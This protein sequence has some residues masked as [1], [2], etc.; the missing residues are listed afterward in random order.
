MLNRLLGAVLI[1]AQCL[2]G[3][4]ALAQQQVQPRAGE[5]TVA[6]QVA[7]DKSSPLLLQADDMIYD[8][9]N[10]RV[11][12]RG[13]VEIYYNDYVL[14]AD[15]VA[16]DRSAN[17]LTAI[18]NVRIKE[19]DGAVINA[20]RLTLRDDFRDGF[21]RSLR[22]VTQDDAR[23][24]ASNAY[25]KD[26]Q[27]TVY[28]NGVFTPCKPCE[29]HPERPPIWRVKSTKIIH[30]KAEQNIYYENAQFE[31][32]GIPVAWVPYFY[33][34]DPQVKQRSGFLMPYYSSSSQLGYTVAVPYYYAASPNYDLTLTPEFTTN[35]GYL[36]QTEW[37]QRLWDGAYKINLAG[38]Y[39]DNAGDFVNNRKFRGSVQTQGDFAIGSL[40]HFGWNATLESDDTF[41]RFYRLD[42]I[43]ATER[44]SQVY[45]TGI[46]D[47]NYF[48]MSLYRFGN[49]TGDTFNVDTGT[50]QKAI[51]ATAYPVID[52][53]YVHNKPV[54]GGEFSFDVNALALT[55]DDPSTLSSTF[56]R[57]TDHVVTQAQWRRTL[58]DDFGQRFTPFGQARG[59]VYHVSSF[60]DI[61]GDSG[62]DDTFTRQ[63]VLGGLDY[64]YPFVA[65]TDNASHVIEPVAQIIARSNVANNDKVP[66]EDSQS[67]VFDDT[68]LFDINKFSGY[69]RIETGTRANY[70]LQYTM[71]TYNGV[72]VRV[73]GGESVQVAGKNSFDPT[74]GLA[75]DRSD[76]VLGGYVDWR[77]MF[78]LV[79]QVRLNESDFSFSA[80]NYSVQ[81]KL[82]FFQGA[83]SYISVQPQP[84]LGFID[85]RQEVAGFAAFK[86]NDDW[87]VFG[88]L[89]YDVELGQFLR[90]SIG[91]QYSDE[92]FTLSVTYAQTFIEFQDIK[93]DTTVMVRLGL[94]YLG[95][96]T[97]SDSIGDLSPEAA[98]FK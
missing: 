67:L 4:S 79:S 37:R 70:G 26:G 32:F 18:G 91:V 44:I 95:Q 90:N 61:N 92:C 76:Y 96:Q 46:G 58:T 81:T 15:E 28:E 69:D 82:G 48:N 80:Q 42:S 50:Y 12:A 41:R 85:A 64:R 39:N 47:R 34:P 53:N 54:L 59:D 35:A 31:V 7:G 14:L 29:E 11:V 77:N 94:K 75:T 16:Y 1:G 84:A 21:I 73:V 36:M 30:D 43:Y 78:R 93:P 5:T 68:L 62:P 10:N 22:A 65:H 3:W 72:S 83:V 19:P 20:D 25:R 9:R 24:A 56:R 23:I 89:R 87:T 71:Q 86:L 66:N 57:D 13:H 33:M 63:M 98:V 51:T 60:R 17:T 97:V 40:W 88:D 55:V 38:A 74:T 8:N 2:L 6:K 49:L 52:Y 45:L 27:T